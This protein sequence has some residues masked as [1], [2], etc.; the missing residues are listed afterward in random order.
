MIVGA[1]I[2]GASVMAELCSRRLR[3][4][5][6]DSQGDERLNA[7][8]LSGGLVRGFD[9]EASTRDAAIESVYNSEVLRSPSSGFRP[10]GALV[11]GVEDAEADAFIDSM[12]ARGLAGSA[13][14]LHGDLHPQFGIRRSAAATVYEPRA[15]TVAPGLLARNFIRRAVRLPGSTFYEGETVVALEHLDNARVRVRTTSRT[16]TTRMVVLAIGAWASRGLPGAVLP[17][18]VRSRAIQVSLVRRP[19]GATHPTFFDRASGIYGAPIDDSTSLVGLACPEWDGFPATEFPDPV[20]A[21]HERETLR[22]AS[23]LLP[24][25]DPDDAS[26]ARR[27]FDAFTPGTQPVVATAGAPNVLAIRP[28]GGA[29]V[30]IAP[31]VARMA[32]DGVVR[33]L[34]RVDRLT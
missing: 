28:M 6:V 29:G 23:Q 5:V 34:G 9:I 7:T 2:I 20:S 4:V 8:A 22:Q 21:S 26:A 10:W 24:W 13:E 14:V 3:S 17:F 16:I 12:S 33:A 11:I 32:A 30:K 27:G 18:P 31:W 19:P 25:L 15:G 1:G